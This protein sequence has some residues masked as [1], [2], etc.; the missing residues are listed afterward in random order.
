MLDMSLHCV[1]IKSV[2]LSVLRITVIISQ[3]FLNK[4]QEECFRAPLP[5]P[6]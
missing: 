6:Q 5:L 1:V 3:L 2:L 4:V